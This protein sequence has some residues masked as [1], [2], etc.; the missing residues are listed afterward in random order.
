MKRA[1]SMV[2]VLGLAAAA[3]HCASVTVYVSWPSPEELRQATD[4]IV[5][6]VRPDAPSTAPTDAS[7]NAGRRGR[8]TSRGCRF[9]AAFAERV[10]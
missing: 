9:E 4:A 3:F 2:M 7:D 10:Q 6:D 5:E 1:A 8:A